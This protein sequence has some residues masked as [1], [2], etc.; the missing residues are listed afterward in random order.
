LLE[1]PFKFPYTECMKNKNTIVYK[2]KSE[3]NEELAN[4]TGEFVDF[5][6]GTIRDRIHGCQLIKDHKGAA[7]LNDLFDTI[8]EKLEEE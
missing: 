8:I 4:T 5:V 2:T 7:I 1:V 3:M 6:L